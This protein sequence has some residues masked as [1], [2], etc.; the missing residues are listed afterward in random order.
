[1]NNRRGPGSFLSRRRKPTGRGARASSSR[2]RLV[3][4]ESR[5]SAAEESNCLDSGRRVSEPI[6]RAAGREPRLLRVDVELNGKL[7]V[8]R[9]V[10]LP[11][12]ESPQGVSR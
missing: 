9:K 11:G 6:A 5:L 8:N 12:S 2:S 1:M 4:A 7:A 10:P 3:G